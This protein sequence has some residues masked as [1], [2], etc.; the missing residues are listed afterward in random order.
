ME[1][2]KVEELNDFSKFRSREP[3]NFSDNFQIKNLGNIAQTGDGGIINENSYQ[4]SYN[5]N[6]KIGRNNLSNN[7]NDNNSNTNILI[8]KNNTSI[9]IYPTEDSYTQT[10]IKGD[11]I[12]QLKNKTKNFYSQI[13]EL[14]D[15]V[16]QLQKN[17]EDYINILKKDI[18]YLLHLE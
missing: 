7:Y 15:K 11:E 13:E 2:N 14:T 17:E 8:N 5:I 12:E 18:N 9:P 10:L 6:S 1:K 3:N 4:G 16:Q